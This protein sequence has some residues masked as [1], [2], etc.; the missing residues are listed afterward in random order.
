MWRV[1]IKGLLAHKLRLALTALAIVLGVTFIAGTFVLTDTLNRTFDTL[2][3]N[4]YQNVDFQVRGVAQLGTRRQRATATPCPSRSLATVRAVPGVQAAEGSVTGLAQ[5]V[6]HD[7]KAISPGGAPTLGVSFDPNQQISALH[8]AQGRPP[9][10]PND[11]AHG[12]RHGAEVQLHGRPESAHSAAGSDPD[13]HHHRPRRASARRTTSPGPPWPRSTSQPHRRSSAMSGSSTTSTSSRRPAPTSR[14]SSVT[15]RACCPRGVEV[16][17]GQTVDQRA[18]ERHQPGARLLQHGP[19]RLRL[20]RAVRGRLHHLEHV[21]HHRGAAHAR[22]GAPAHRGGQPPPGLPLGPRRGGR[23][24]LVSSLVGLG[25]GV[26]AA[27]GLEKLLGG[28]GVTLPSGSHRVRHPH[29]DRRPPRWRR[30]D[31]GGGHRPG[32]ARRADRPGGGG[33]R[34]P[35]RG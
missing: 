7:G 19:P 25:L 34:P 26:L 3:G 35:D 16:V 4:I 15:S 22:A 29:G 14:P 9:T 12:P 10:T 13:L 6:A 28:F 32:A 27:I 30:R 33:V 20:H 8:I 2:F 5:F 23:R 21:L 17:T 18:D 1:T 11:V 24:G 31:H